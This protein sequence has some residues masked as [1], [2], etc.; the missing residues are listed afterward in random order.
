MKIKNLVLAALVVMGFAAC[1]DDSNEGINGGAETKYDTFLELTIKSPE[2]TRTP[3]DDATTKESAIGDV[4]VYLVNPSTL[5]IVRSERTSIASGTTTAKI[6]VPTGTY[7]LFVVVNPVGTTKGSGNIQEVISGVTEADAKGGYKD[8]HGSGKFMMVTACDDNDKF[9]GTDVTITSANT[10]S[11]PCEARV[12][13]DRVAAKISDSTEADLNGVTIELGSTDVDEKDKF[14]TLMT[15]AVLKGLVLINGNEEFNLLQTWTATV[16]EAGK[17]ITD[18]VLTTPQGELTGAAGS[19][20]MTGYYNPI[21]KFAKVTKVDGVITKIED[22]T[23]DA[24]F[25]LYPDKNSALYTIENRPDF[26]YTTELTSGR[27]QT[28]GVIY[29]IV[30]NGG[31]T[32]YS[33]KDKIHLTDAELKAAVPL[34]ATDEFF[35]KPAAEK[36]A[37]GV[38]VYENGK[39]YYTYFIQD[40]QY[41]VKV[42]GGAE[43][44]YN[45]VM[46]NAYYKM[47]IKSIKALGD[48]VP[49]GGKVTPEDPNPPIVTGDLKLTVEL[50]VRPWVLNVI[51]IDF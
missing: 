9:E 10:D 42:D 48:D 11:N 19:Q 16:T 5:N 25:K 43:V 18:H 15:G 8:G 29:R 49:D 51:G 34:I 24:D 6:D 7:K 28:T 39:M 50:T 32:F 45:A 14:Q 31:Q 3:T 20:A 40:Q 35:T 41:K 33:Y 46:R 23:T 47:N 26:M 17:N 38:Q 2:R 21:T 1:S 36:R 27:A 44:P 4:D 37:L 30:A 12:S 13:V 22:L